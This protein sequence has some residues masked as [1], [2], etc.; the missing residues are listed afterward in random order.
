MDSLTIVIGIIPPT[1]R[2]PMLAPC[3]IPHE[4][5][6]TSWP[7][8]ASE[9]I[10]GIRCLVF[11]KHGA[12][13]RSGCRFRNPHLARTISEAQAISDRYNL[14]IEGELWAPGMGP[15]EMQ[16]A[17]REREP[18][19]GLQLMIF[20]AISYAEFEGE[21][22]TP[23]ERR[24]SLAMATLDRLSGCQVLEQ[25]PMD[26]WRDL[27]RL[28][29]QVKHDGGEGLMIRKPSGMYHHGRCSIVSA[30]IFKV[31]PIHANSKQAEIPSGLEV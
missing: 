14:V 10:D 7:M 11:P 28:Y 6:I 4:H 19:R 22:A 15:T 1:L 27:C 13:S 2:Q 21:S 17:L 3:R 20:D 5:E 29:R 18:I 16:I 24:H 26:N 25:Q 8:L 12:R 30:E 23:F 9:K 31:R